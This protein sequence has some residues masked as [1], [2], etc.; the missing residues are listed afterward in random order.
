MR[1]LKTTKNMKVI[2]PCYVLDFQK[3]MDEQGVIAPR[4]KFPVKYGK[5]GLIGAG[6]TEEICNLRYLY[7][8]YSDKWCILFYSNKNHYKKR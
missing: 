5:F 6:W 4:I 8:F 3:W 2:P 7:L 1:I